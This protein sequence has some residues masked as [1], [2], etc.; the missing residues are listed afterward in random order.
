MIPADGLP[1]G[2]RTSAAG[3]GT[4]GG[5]DLLVQALEGLGVRPLGRKKDR[6]ALFEIR[7]KRGETPRAAGP[8]ILRRPRRAA[9][10][11]F[12]RLASPEDAFLRR[13]VRDRRSK[14]RSTDARQ[15]DRV[16]IF[17][18]AWG[19]PGRR[20]NDF[21]IPS[22]TTFQGESRRIPTPK[23]SRCR[24]ERARTAPRAGR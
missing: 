13:P 5:F 11:F 18:G 3:Q 23:S 12:G 21:S 10:V 2:R 19:R 8:K 14:A 4:E 15:K 7:E 24:P 22:R 17:P 1:G 20:V 16:R 9:P 6:G